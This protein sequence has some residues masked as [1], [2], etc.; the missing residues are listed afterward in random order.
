MNFKIRNVYV[1]AVTLFFATFC[2]FGCMPEKEVVFS[3]NTMA[4]AYNIKVVTGYFK[5]TAYIKDLVE[6]RLNEIDNSM[7]TYIKNSEISGFNALKNTHTKYDVS[8]DFLYV[9]MTA[10][11]LHKITYGAWDGTI[12]PL[13]KLW[14]FEDRIIMKN[15]PEKEEIEQKLSTIGF[16]N[17]IISEKGYIRKKE[18]RIS[19]DLASIAKGYAVDQLAVLLK[20]LK[21]DD[22]I[23]EIGGEV[24][25][26]GLR[27]DGK[28][29]KVGINRPDRNASF[30]DVYKVVTLGNKALATSGDYRNFFEIDGKR[31][32]HVLDPETGYPVSNG[33]VSVTVI[34]DMCAFAD[35]L[36]TAIMVLGH[37]KGIELANHIN[38]VECMIIVQGKNGDL[39]DYYSDNF[40]LNFS[41]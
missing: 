41:K 4:T 33:V 10:K 27:K 18:S 23:V 15:V 20:S 13:V 11:Y 8:D 37:E 9:L 12:K 7:S 25:A 39:T 31:Y 24:Y 40:K 14:G 19:L 17:I 32:S 22:F 29:W 34:S 1:Y 35:G 36:A 30:N 6:K 28:K 21:I 5:K 2:L 16:D 38:D 3:G 26:S